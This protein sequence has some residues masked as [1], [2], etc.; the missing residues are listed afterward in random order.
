M[1]CAPSRMGSEASTSCCGLVTWRRASTPKAVAT[2]PVVR[3]ASAEKHM[4]PGWRGVGAGDGAQVVEDLPVRFDRRGLAIVDALVLAE[5][6]DD[7]RRFSEVAARHGG[8]EV[9]L[10]L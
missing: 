6:A 10:D 9:M 7:G 1:V 8:E 2:R 5:L 4:Q 3:S